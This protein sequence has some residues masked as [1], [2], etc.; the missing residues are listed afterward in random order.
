MDAEN[1]QNRLREK[2]IV[3]CEELIRGEIGVIAASRELVSLFAHMN[4]DNPDF[5]FFKAVESETDHLPIGEER[6]NWNA[7]ALKQKDIEISENEL[8]Y[9]NEMIETCQKVISK[10]KI[11]N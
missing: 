11:K 10:L 4:M 1:Y 6:K 7:E 2:T 3:V 5:V 8:F 9:K